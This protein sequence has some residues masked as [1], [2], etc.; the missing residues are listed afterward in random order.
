[1]VG[2]TWSSDL[3]DRSSRPGESALKYA[4]LLVEAG[5]IPLLIP[6]ASSTNLLDRLDG[7][8]LPGG[9]DI[10][11]SHYGQ[12]PSSRLEAVVPELDTLELDFAHAARSRHLPILGICRGQ[13]LINVALGGTLHQHVA[14]P[15]KDDDLSQ[16][17]HE[18]E[19]LAGTHLHRVLGVERAHVNSGHHQAVDEIAPP[20]RVSAR[21]TDGIVEAL[22]A[23]DLMILAVQ[24]HPDEMPADEISR[25]L[26]AGF[27]GWFA[28]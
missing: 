27:A 22:E 12:E 21:S 26:M 19:I 4:N 23:E 1:M 28:D 14:H 18:I 6:P 17:A 3:V 25:R 11:P 2:I 13:Q 15:Q 20:L 24:W 10:A 16:P 7:L 8:M 9:P 5:M